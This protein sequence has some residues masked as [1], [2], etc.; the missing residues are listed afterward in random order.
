MTH[1]RCPVSHHRRTEIFRIL[2]HSI[3]PK[4]KSTLVGRV[5]GGETAV[6]ALRPTRYGWPS[7]TTNVYGTKVYVCR[8]NTRGCQHVYHQ[9]PTYTPRVWLEPPREHGLRPLSRTSA[10]GGRS[11]A[12]TLSNRNKAS[13][14]SSSR[15]EKSP[16]NQTKNTKTYK[17]ITPIPSRA[18]RHNRQKKNQV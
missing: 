11:S 12:A 18:S 1:V 7:P 13:M 2:N 6:R 17:Q 3:G 10:Q 5:G 15:T 16:W 4:A 14:R 9:H 8:K